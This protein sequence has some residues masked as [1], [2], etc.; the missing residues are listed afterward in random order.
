MEKKTYYIKRLELFFSRRR[1]CC[2]CFI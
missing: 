2:I 1:T